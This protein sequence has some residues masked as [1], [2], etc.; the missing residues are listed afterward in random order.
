MGR[1]YNTILKADGKK[2]QLNLDASKFMLNSGKPIDFFSIFYFC[3]GLNVT[4]HVLQAKAVQMKLLNF[5]C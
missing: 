1:K 5:N 3:K 2:E 4:H